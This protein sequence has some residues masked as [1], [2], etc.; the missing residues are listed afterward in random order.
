VITPKM[1]GTSEVSIHKN[2]ILNPEHI[3]KKKIDM[4]FAFK[5][6][7]LTLNKTCKYENT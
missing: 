3:K 7:I 4:I 2:N 6:L 5:K 1:A